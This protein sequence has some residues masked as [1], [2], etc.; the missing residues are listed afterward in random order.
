MT[1]TPV[2]PQPHL[3]TITGAS[4][5]LDVSTRTIRRYIAAGLLPAY[6]IGP[7]QVRIK[8]RDLERLLRRIPAVGDSGA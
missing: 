6:R 5:D 7:R 2:D 8:R 3:L 1:L 4:A